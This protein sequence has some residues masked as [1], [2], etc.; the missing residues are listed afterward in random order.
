MPR[1]KL[2]AHQKRVSL[3]VRIQPETLAALVKHQ[4]KRS[5]PNKARALDDLLK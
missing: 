5:L 2:P 1:P 3:N 4:L